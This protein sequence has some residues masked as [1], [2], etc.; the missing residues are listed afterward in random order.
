MILF[1]DKNEHCIDGPS[2]QRR[3][4]FEFYIPCNPKWIVDGYVL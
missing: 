1:P 2:K 4:Y 3:L